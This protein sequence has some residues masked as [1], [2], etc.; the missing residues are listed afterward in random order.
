[1]LTVCD[2]CGMQE[3]ELRRTMGSI[4]GSTRRATQQQLDSVQVQ[5]EESGGMLGKIC[6]MFGK[7]LKLGPSAEGGSSFKGKSGGKGKTAAGTDTAYAIVDECSSVSRSKPSASGRKGTSNMS[8]TS[9]NSSHRKVAPNPAASEV[10][11]L[12][13]RSVTQMQ[14]AGLM[15]QIGR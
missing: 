4:D 10:L 15:M 5:K 7:L 1:M 2:V 11:G 14:A 6:K 8:F 9:G 3:F 13:T 12:R